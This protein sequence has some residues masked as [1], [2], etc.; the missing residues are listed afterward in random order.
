MAYEA[1]RAE[2][3]RR[4]WMIAAAFGVLAF[5]I[6]IFIFET[7]VFLSLFWSLLL[8]SA[9]GLT[10]TCFFRD[11]PDASGVVA[12]DPQTKPQRRADPHTGR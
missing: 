6:M 10:L 8:S 2:C 3:T 1:E 11:V 5:A 4:G 12:P 9:I 7:S